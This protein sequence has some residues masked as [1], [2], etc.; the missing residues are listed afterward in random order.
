M[1]FGRNPAKGAISGPGM[2]SKAIAFTPT[3]AKVVGKL[4]RAGRKW[5]PEK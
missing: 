5:K 4:S 1:V 2:A 3:W